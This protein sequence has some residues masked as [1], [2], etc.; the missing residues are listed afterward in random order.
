[1]Q[2]YRRKGCLCL[3]VALLAG[4]TGMEKS[5]KEKIR[6]LNEVR[7]PIYRLSSDT[8]TIKGIDEPKQRKRYP[9]EKSAFPQITQDFFRCKGS[10]KNIGYES[11]DCRGPDE[12]SLPLKGGKEHIP[13]TL[14]ELLDSIQERLKAKLIITCGHRCM[15]HHLFAKKEEDP[16]TSKHLM[17]AEVDFYVKGLEDK[18]LE[19]VAAIMEYYKERPEVYLNQFFKVEKSRSKRYPAWM[20]KEIIIHL[21][22]KNEGRDL[23][24]NHSYPYICIELRVDYNSLEV[25]QPLQKY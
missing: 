2:A 15:K 10:S 22:D 14:V 19:V 12:H 1:M 24:N 16:K 25:S 13:K 20:N 3:L 7:E 21:L 23:D 17:G 11:L 18:P 4:C 6:K 8:L 5:E 9:W